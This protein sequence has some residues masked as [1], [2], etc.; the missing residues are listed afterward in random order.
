MTQQQFHLAFPFHLRN[1]VEARLDE[2]DYVEQL[3]EMVL[4]TVKGERVNLPDFGCGIQQLVFQTIDSA[5]VPATLFLVKSELQRYVTQY[6]VIQ[7]VNVVDFGPELIVEVQ[8]SLVGSPQ[9]RI[10]RYGGAGR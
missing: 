8:Y 2:S 3:I 5:L 6:A 4:F 9:Q 10:A 7:D 1:G